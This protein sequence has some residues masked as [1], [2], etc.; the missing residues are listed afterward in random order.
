M[1]KGSALVAAF[2]GVLITFAM[3][4]VLW[5]NV[6]SASVEP[7]RDAIYDTSQSAWAIAMSSLIVALVAVGRVS[8]DL[9]PVHRPPRY[10][11][12]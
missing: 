2:T 9:K 12:V 3:W 6:W 10:R 8:L 7:V 5:E 1:L 4:V 11:S